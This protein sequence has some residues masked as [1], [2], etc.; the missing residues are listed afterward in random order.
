MSIYEWANRWRVPPQAMRELLDMGL[1][2]QGPTNATE[3]ATQQQ[4]RLTASRMG[5]DMWRYNKVVDMR[6]ITFLDRWDTKENLP[7]NGTLHNA[8]DDAVWQALYVS[9]VYQKLKGATL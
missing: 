1:P 3:A 8:L 7:F 6:T 5:A 2:A 4:I 9:T